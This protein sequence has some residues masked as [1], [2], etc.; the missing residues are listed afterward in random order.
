MPYSEYTIWNVLTYIAL[1]FVSIAL[2]VFLN[3]TQPFVLED[4]LGIKDDVVS[5]IRNISR[6]NNI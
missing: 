5:T 2:L 4:I 3:S 1:C 6:A